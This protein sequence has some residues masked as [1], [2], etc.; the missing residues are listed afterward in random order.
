MAGANDPVEIYPKAFFVRDASALHRQLGPEWRNG[1]LPLEYVRTHLAGPGADDP[2]DKALRIDSNV[3]LVDDP[4]KRVDNMTMAWGLEAR[5]PFL[6]HELV[7]LAGRIPPELK[8]RG[9]GK[10]VLTEAA[11]RVIPRAVIA[12]PKGYFPVPALKHLAGP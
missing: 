4:V 9:D 7:E 10:W 12:R 8:V 2:V 5:V 1:T 6:D 11:R 3:M